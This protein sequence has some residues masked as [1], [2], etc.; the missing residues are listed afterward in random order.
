MASITDIVT[1]GLKYPFNDTKKLLTLGVAFLLVSLLSLFSQYLT[2]Q[3][4]TAGFSGSGFTNVSST[5]MI[6][7]AIISIIMFIILFFVVG[8]SYKVIRYG[9]DNKTE[10]PEF[11]DPLKMILNGL[12]A[13]VVGFLYSIP[14]LLLLVL[15]FLLGVNRNV[16]SGINS[17]GIILIVIAALFFIFTY[18]FSVMAISHM[19]AGDKLSNAFKFKEITAIIS[20]L[21]WFKYIGIVL[22]ALIVFVVITIFFQIIFGM[23]ASLFGYLLGSSLVALIISALL[24]SLLVQPYCSIFLSRVFGSLYRVAN[25]A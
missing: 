7:V 11:N 13:V 9:I 5:N 15:G 25:E 8:Y 14:P 10:L 17:V 6:L 2:F 23:V 19:V 12:K 18:F 22:F 1:E 24:I 16:G 20:K 4:I 21:G 3:S